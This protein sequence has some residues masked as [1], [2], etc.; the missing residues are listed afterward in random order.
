MR[1][2]QMSNKIEGPKV[3]KDKNG[4]VI[5]AGDILFRKFF[6]RKR[7]RPGHKRVAFNPM[8]SEES[9][10]LDEGKL[11]EK[12]ISSWIARKVLWSGACMI[13]NVFEVSDYQA[14]IGGHEQ[15]DPNSGK[16]IFE[17][18]N[19]QY[20]NNGFDSSVYEIVDHI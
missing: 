17:S 12:Q 19:F 15:F 6:I 11:L 1:R 20:M 13:A 5:K 18:N 10:V 3:F 9:I 7:E 8:S 16:R 2:K 14:I 4:H